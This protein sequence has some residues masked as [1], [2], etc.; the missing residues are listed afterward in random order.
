MIKLMQ[1]IVI[2]LLIQTFFYCY[3]L[4]Y[5]PDRLR[6]RNVIIDPPIQLEQPGAY[7]IVGSTNVNRRTET[8]IPP[9]AQ[10]EIIPQMD[11]NQLSFSEFIYLILIGN[12]LQKLKA[13]I[14]DEDSELNIEA[15]QN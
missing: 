15:M 10:A 3:P 13:E 12:R 4:H 8:D 7:V 5:S 6:R 11:S 1:F 14:L 9:L 2:L